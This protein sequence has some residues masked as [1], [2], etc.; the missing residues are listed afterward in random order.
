M[1]FLDSLDFNES[2]LFLLIIF[3]IV[4]IA[5]AYLL[6]FCFFN[7]GFK[8]KRKLLSNS[9]VDDINTPIDDIISIKRLEDYKGARRP[10]N[11]NHLFRSSFQ[12]FDVNNQILNNQKNYYINENE[13][14]G[15][16]DNI[17]AEPN[18]LTVSY[19]G[20]L[21]RKIQFSQ[22]YSTILPLTYQNYDI[23]D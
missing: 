2:L 1:K 12:Q 8:R 6:F 20:F 13:N 23:D 21:G 11:Q 9:I 22:H 14:L 18:N 17:R 19:N 16:N 15:E 10:R 4:L 3:L 5:I 7:N